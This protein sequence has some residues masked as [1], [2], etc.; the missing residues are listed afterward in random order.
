MIAEE[1]IEKVEETAT[2][3]ATDS[4]SEAMQNEEM[5][6]VNDTV[7]MV[8]ESVSADGSLSTEAAVTAASADVVLRV[9][10]STAAAD[11][12]RV[13]TSSTSAPASPAASA[14]PTSVLFRSAS[15][16]AVL[17]SANIQFTSDTP[18]A[19]DIDGTTPLDLK[20]PTP[21]LSTTPI[22]LPLS[23]APS[24]PPRTTSD[25]PLHTALTATRPT[26]C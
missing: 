17:P 26:T 22:D 5:K 8:V 9:V 14:A 21:L 11:E 23:E 4:T 1:W 3:D 13:E 19:A 16:P 12:Q 25:P 18:M 20:Q 10:D 6:V 15:T 7:D 2:T 24:H